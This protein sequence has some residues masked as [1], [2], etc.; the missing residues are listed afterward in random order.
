MPEWIREFSC[1][2]SCFA[3][4]TVLT[5][6]QDNRVYLEFYRHY[7]ASCAPVLRDRG[8]RIV[9]RRGVGWTVECK[10]WVIAPILHSYS[11]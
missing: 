2:F 5:L 6:W 7:S 10:F 11:A 8:D 4:G 9:L 1:F 3:S